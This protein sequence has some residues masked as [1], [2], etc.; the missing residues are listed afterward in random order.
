MKG[1]QSQVT[2]MGPEPKEMAFR[3]PWNLEQSQPFWASVKCSWTSDLPLTLST[4]TCRNPLVTMSFGVKLS[5]DGLSSVT[6]PLVFSPRTGPHEDEGAL[7]EMNRPVLR[8]Q[9]EVLFKKK[10]AGRGRRKK[11]NICIFVMV[12]GK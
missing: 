10:G 6:L 11:E 2:E 3:R 9:E 7:N 12:P 8:L 4:P 1:S 5:L